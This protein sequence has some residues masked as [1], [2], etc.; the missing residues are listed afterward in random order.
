M[1]YFNVY[2]G[3]HFRI[4]AFLCG[5]PFLSR[6]LLAWDNH[7]LRKRRPHPNFRSIYRSFY[8]PDDPVYPRLADC[9]H[10]ILRFCDKVRRFG[11]CCFMLWLNLHREHFERLL[12]TPNCQAVHARLH[13]QKF[14]KKRPK[15]T[16]YRLI[17]RRKRLGS[18]L[19]DKIDASQLLFYELLYR[20]HFVLA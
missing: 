19:V 3:F 16:S 4:I 1:N 13:Q 7:L 6:K 15:V 20:S 14:H 12:H 5:E 11:R 17:D 2:I 8:N 18:E 9:T 10:G